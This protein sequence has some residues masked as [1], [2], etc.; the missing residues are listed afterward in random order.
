MEADGMKPMRSHVFKLRFAG[1]D[2]NFVIDDP[3]IGDGAFGGRII[4]VVCIGHS[5]WNL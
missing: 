1:L 5:F 2:I 4:E 3:K